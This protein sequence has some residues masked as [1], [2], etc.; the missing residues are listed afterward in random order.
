MRITPKTYKAKK[1]ARVVAEDELEV[2]DEEMIEEPMP[3]ELLFEGSEVADL[4]AQVTGEE[5]E[6]ESDEDKVIFRIGEDEY[7]VEP[8]GDEEILEA[9]RRPLKNKKPV[10]AST[11]KPMQRRQQPAAKPTKARR[12]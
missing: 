1:P 3:T 5:V 10:K 7:T 11:R 9:T 4:L 6:M 12:N 2:Y 8:E